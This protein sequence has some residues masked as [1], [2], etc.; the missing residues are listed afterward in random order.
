MGAMGR[1][2]PIACF[3]C[4]IHDPSASLPYIG[5][6]EH[7]VVIYFIRGVC[8]NTWTFTP[9]VP[10]AEHDCET[11]KHNVEPQKNGRMITGKEHCLGPLII[12]LIFWVPLLAN[13]GRDGKNNFVV[14]VFTPQRNKRYSHVM[15]SLYQH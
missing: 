13:V 14:S 5:Q 1:N 10:S 11:H 6:R 9:P 3:K 12:L 4:P 8:Y 7:S 2:G 15:N